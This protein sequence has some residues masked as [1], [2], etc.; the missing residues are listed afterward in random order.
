[1]FLPYIKHHTIK[2]YGGVEVD[3]ITPSINL[4]IRWR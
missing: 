2:M 3:Y 4:D 1:M